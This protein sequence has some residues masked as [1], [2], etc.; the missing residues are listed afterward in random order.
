MHSDA[1]SAASETRSKHGNAFQTRR[2]TFLPKT[3]AVAQ[4]ARDS[5]LNSAHLKEG[6]REM[7]LAVSKGSAFGR[8]RPFCARSKRLGT[9]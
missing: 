2:A 7:S 8:R 6:S 1:L 5:P 3:K 4:K 9:R